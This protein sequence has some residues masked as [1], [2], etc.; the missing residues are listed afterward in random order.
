M[1]LILKA[2]VIRVPRTVLDEVAASSFDISQFRDKWGGEEEFWYFQLESLP[3]EADV[4]LLDEFHVSGGTYGA[5]SK[6]VISF[7]R[8]VSCYFPLVDFNPVRTVE[9]EARVVSLYSFQAI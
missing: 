3:S 4:I 7:G 9:I 8:N 2:N 6:L 1:Q 5:L